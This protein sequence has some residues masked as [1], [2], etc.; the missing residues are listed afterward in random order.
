MAI[1]DCV[2]S[3][4]LAILLSLWVTGQSMCAQPPETAFGAAAALE[5]VMVEAIARVE[6]SVVAIARVRKEQAT[7]KLAPELRP[8]P[9]N[10][11]LLPSRRPKPTEPEFIPNEFATGV[12]ID[13]H[14]L[15]LTVYHVLG[16]ESD[17]YVTTPHRKVYRA[18]IIAADPR[19]DLAVLALDDFA[20]AAVDALDFPP[21]VLGDG[22]SL[23]KGQIVL[24]LGNPY[25]IAAD[26]QASACW[27][28]VSNLARKA[29]S[30]PDEWD[31]SGKSTIHHFGTLIQTDAKLNWGTSGGAL[32]NLRGEMVGLVT[33]LPMTP[34]CEEA[35][36]YAIPVDSTFR[37]ILGV[38]KTGKEV[39]Y[40]FLGI[41]PK[42]L[43][44]DEV[45]RGVQGV[46]VSR[47]VPGTPAF[48][49]GIRS[50]DLIAA[51]NSIPIHDADGLVLEVGRLPVESV[52]QLN[53]IHRGSEAHVE[54]PLTKYRVRGKKIVTVPAPEWRGMRVDYSS[55]ADDAL[56]SGPSDPVLLDQAVLV[57][58]V[59]QGTPAWQ[60]GLR[61]GMFISQVDYASV[62]TP[63]EFHA[64]VAKK[65]GIVRLRLAAEEGGSAERIVPPNS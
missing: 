9:F 37:R 65:T 51:V 54:V 21:I 63:K 45:L 56:Q 1:R 43:T 55:V 32:L 48:R 46:R 34:G 22:A 16:E 25:G 53:V 38:L 7:E 52:V 61:P 24:S 50:G 59:S 42:S 44:T 62:H 15:I 4:G 20:G 36:G 33:S 35:A 31:M 39:E 27:G 11:R 6:K 17:Y 40:G 2:R 58:D 57:T 12:V 28:I 49:F 23:R 8:D 10:R 47:V 26:G 64:A 19:S 41:E 60:A 5:G 3:I 14:G 13:S 29:P 30:A 18:R